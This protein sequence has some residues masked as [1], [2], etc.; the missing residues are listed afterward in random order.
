MIDP[1][2]IINHNLNNFDLQELFLFCYAVA[3][4]NSDQTADKINALSVDILCRDI[5]AENNVA[6]PLEYLAMLPKEDSESILRQHKVGKYT[7]WNAMLK[8]FSYRKPHINKILRRGSHLYLE[9]FKGV[10]QKTSRFFLS[11]SRSGTRYAVLDTHIL[12]Y[13]REAGYKAPK[14]TPRGRS[15]HYWEAIAL[16]R[17]EDARNEGES[18]ADVDLRIWRLYSGR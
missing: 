6:G 3:G 1:K 15:Y 18:L 2:N 12:R 17:M 13:L 10:G 16:S 14:S 8:Q 4:K 11:S 9:C 5:M 7:N